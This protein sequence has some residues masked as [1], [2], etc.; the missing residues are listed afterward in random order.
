MIFV[1]VV[2]FQVHNPIGNF[3]CVRIVWTAAAWAHVRISSWLNANKGAHGPSQ[4]DTNLGPACFGPGLILRLWY[5]G[6]A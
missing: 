2:K 4:P 6:R 5:K 3:G 1:L